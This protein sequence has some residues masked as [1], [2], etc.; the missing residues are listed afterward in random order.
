MK[1]HKILTW[2]L[3][4]ILMLSTPVMAT[5]FYVAPDGNDKWSGTLQT[6]NAAQTDGPLATLT[7][8]RNAVRHLKQNGPLKSPVMILVADGSYPISTAFELLPEDSGTPDAPITYRA[9]SGSTPVFP[10]GIELTDIRID[11]QG[12]WRIALPE[13]ATGNWFFEQLFVNQRR[14]TRART[15]NQY[16]SYIQNIR[17]EVLEAGSGRY[18][19]HARQ[20]IEL[21]ASDAGLLQQCLDFREVL[22]V[23]FH[24]WDITRKRILEF[25]PATNTVMIEGE[26][27]KPWNPIERGTRYIL[28]NLPGALDQAGEWYLDPRGELV[29]LPRPGETPENTQII[30]PKTEK[31]IVVQGDPVT[32]TR[33]EHISI[34]DLEFQFANFVLP[35]TGFD[36]LQAAVK[37]DAAVQI[38]Y[39]RRIQ[40]KNCRF[41]HVGQYGVWFREGCTECRLEHCLVNDLG[42]GG[43]RIGTEKIITE[44]ERQTAQIVV[45]NNIIQSGSHIFTCA[46]GVWIGQSGHNEVIRNDIGDFG[47]TGISAGWTWGY[48]QSLAKHN[49]IEFNHIHH[50]GWGILSD[51]GGVY[52]LGISEGTTVSNNC[53]HD[54]YAHTY[55]GW[56]LY[57]DEGSSQIRLENNLVY[58]T[59]TGGF[60]QHYGEENLIQNNIFAFSHL[61]QLQC[62]R[63]EPHRSFRFLK[64]IVYWDFGPL[65]G[66]PWVQVQLE[67]DRNCYFQC[68]KQPFDFA[69]HAFAEWQAADRDKHAVIA[70][71]GFANPEQFDFNLKLNAALKS[72]GFT[73]F[74]YSRAGVYGDPEWLAQAQLAP[75]TLLDFEKV[76]FCGAIS[77]FLDQPLEQIQAAFEPWLRTSTENFVPRHGW[78]FTETDGQILYLQFSAQNFYYAILK[79]KPGPASIYLKR[80]RPDPGSPIHLINREEPLRWTFDESS[81]LKIS[82]PAA[83]PAEN[84][85]V[86]FRIQGRLT[87]ITRPPEIQIQGAAP[88]D[89][90]FFAPPKVQLSAPDS[91]DAIRFTTDGTEPTVQSPKYTRPIEITRPT[92][93]LAAAFK[94]GKIQSITTSRF[95]DLADPAKNGVH[96][97]YFEGEFGGQLPDFTQ[98]TPLKTGRAHQFR[99]KNLAPRPMNFAVR[100]VG[101]LEITRPGEYT[102]FTES[103]DGSRLAINDFIVVENDGEHGAAEKSGVIRL[104]PGRHRVEVTYFQSGGSTALKVSYAGPEIAKQEIPMSRLFLE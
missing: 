51:M 71:P 101:F 64:N 90:V 100:F 36:A 3:K 103:N 62:T 93:L 38:D 104:E 21:E 33:V 5:T 50:I 12:F 45:E 14:A 86:A 35:R 57:P 53:I 65:L 9:Q 80:L 8:A 60:H 99:L 78:T 98:L 95:I 16:Y 39:A 82:F 97:E 54:I 37:I 27:L 25:D 59:K 15:P 67:M 58:Q 41:R 74:D 81:G 66:G 46:V 7:G 89:N 79:S 22:L 40:I 26:G 6:I 4:G 77:V 19:V 88:E 70:D 23:A 92:R 96:F 10:G 17:E 43:V 87:Q 1:S 83:Q 32:G 55:G 85:I 20:Y 31:F 44:P 29:Y 56:G 75:Q 30:A 47:Y 2:L 69:G 48:T 94:S 72:I 28:E 61:Q 73:P 13:V 68:Q 42:A 91:P 11:A 49:K 76:W 84:Q 24:K 18:P 102:F 52:T 63:V 34:E